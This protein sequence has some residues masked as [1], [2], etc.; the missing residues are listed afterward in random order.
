VTFSFR[1]IFI[2]EEVVEEEKDEDNGGG[3]GIAGNNNDDSGDGDE[4]TGVLD[5]LN[6]ASTKR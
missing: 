6:P 4:A 3:D 2:G 5:S 1:S